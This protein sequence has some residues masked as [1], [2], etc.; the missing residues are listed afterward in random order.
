[1]EVGIITSRAF[2]IGDTLPSKNRGLPLMAVVGVPEKCGIREMWRRVMGDVIGW[3]G[4][5]HR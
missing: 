1:M 4:Q 3:I 2:P 5:M